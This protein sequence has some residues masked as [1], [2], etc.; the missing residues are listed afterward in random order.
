MP[1]AG[2]GRHTSTAYPTVRYFDDARRRKEVDRPLSGDLALQTPSLPRLHSHKVR[3]LPGSGA[4]V[5]YGLE[6]PKNQ[7]V[8]NLCGVAAAAVFS[9]VVPVALVAT[10]GPAGS[11]P[12]VVPLDPGDQPYLVLLSG[13]P[14]TKSIRS[15]LVTPAPGTP[16][17][18]HNTEKHDEVRVP[19]AVAVSTML[20]GA[21]EKGLRWLAVIAAPWY[22]LFSTS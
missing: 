12:K 1:L 6:V 11:K 9:A 19:P 2:A 17:G 7:R 16:V 21:A 5:Q 8:R 15:G 4:V 10:S 22:R 13:P 18:V 14:E 3:A 20:S